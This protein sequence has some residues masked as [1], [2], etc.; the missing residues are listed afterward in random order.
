MINLI[1]NFIGKIS[2]VNPISI[3]IGC[4]MLYSVSGTTSFPDISRDY[5]SLFFQES[6]TYP[7][8]DPTLNIFDFG[9]QPVSRFQSTTLSLSVSLGFS[10]IT[11]FPAELIFDLSDLNIS[12]S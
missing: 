3:I 10:N 4:Q 7:G 12:F 9:I 6:G 5:P 11:K 1:P 8:Y 2:D